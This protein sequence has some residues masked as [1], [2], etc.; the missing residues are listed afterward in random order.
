MM[1]LNANGDINFM[2][3]NTLSMLISKH[4]AFYYKQEPSLLPQLFILFLSTYLYTYYPYGNINASLNY[5]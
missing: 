3:L 2:K 4:S 1:S 5:L